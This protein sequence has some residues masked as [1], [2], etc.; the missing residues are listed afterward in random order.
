MPRDNGDI[1]FGDCSVEESGSM[2]VPPRSLEV[3]TIA[4]ALS[5]H[6]K[7]DA[8]A[9]TYAP[10]GFGSHHWIAETTDGEK[11]FVTIDDLRSA[12]LGEN[13]ERA[14]EILGT[15]FRAAAALRDAAKLE[16]VIAP[17]A[18]CSGRWLHR[19]DERYSMAVFP[20]VDVE[21]TEFN[22][23]P[24]E[25]DRT[26]AMRQVGEIH[27]AT[28]Q[29]SVDP[30]RKETFLV[31][32]RTELLQALSALDRPWNAGPYSEPAQRLLRDH[33]TTLLQRLG[34]FDRLAA[35][36]MADR[37][38][39]VVSHGEPHA[40]NIIRTRSGSMV[41]VDWAGVAYAPPERDVWMLL[42]E[43][44]PDWSEYKATTNVTSLSD[45]ALTAYRLYWNLS[46]IAVFVSWCRRPHDQTEEM[47]MVWAELQAYATGVAFSLCTTG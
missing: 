35:E 2:K 28:A 41:V 6:W 20:F 13:E 31:P 46:D 32:K 42:D 21:P 36:V 8:A 24:Q 9:L 25:S 43:A 45:R 5:A 22:A 16:F 3:D 47:E 37:S 27:N 30:L 23:F 1:H 44:N 15:A 7:L 18:D 40:G 33:A 12:Y 38:G 4:V 19:L 17:I 26:G 14:F 39:W 10:L 29:L 11:W 34:Q